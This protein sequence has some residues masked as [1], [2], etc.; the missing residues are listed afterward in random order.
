MQSQPYL[1]IVSPPPHH[2]TMVQDVEEVAEAESSRLVL[3]HTESSLHLVERGVLSRMILLATHLVGHRLTC[4]LLRVRNSIT[5]DFV[6]R[7]SDALLK[8]I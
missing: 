5:L 1:V 3:V 2:V 6:S 4:A 7:I 8:L